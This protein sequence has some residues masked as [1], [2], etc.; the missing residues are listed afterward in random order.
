MAAGSRL[1]P[2][3]LDSST[4]HSRK[5]RKSLPFNI[6][7]LLH[8]TGSLLPSKIISQILLATLNFEVSG[9]ISECLFNRL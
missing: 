8:D 5:D 9:P 1:D 2:W 3:A 6:V 7:A 4:A